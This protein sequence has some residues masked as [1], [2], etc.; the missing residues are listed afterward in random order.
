[1]QTYVLPIQFAA[2]S[3]VSLLPGTAAAYT[4]VADVPMQPLVL[5]VE[6][7]AHDNLVAYLTA[8]TLRVHSGE[9]SKQLVLPFPRVRV[10]SP[11]VVTVVFYFIQGRVWHEAADQVSTCLS[12]LTAALRNIVL[13]YVGTRDP[14]SLHL[15]VEGESRSLEEWRH[16]DVLYRTGSMFL[17]EPTTFRLVI[18]RYAYQMWILGPADLQLHFRRDF[19]W[20]TCERD[21]CA[22]T[23]ETGVHRLTF[24]ACAVEEHQP[25]PWDN[26]Y[27]RV[28]ATGLIE[29]VIEPVRLVFVWSCA[30]ELL[31][32][33]CYVGSSTGSGRGHVEICEQGGEWTSLE[34]RKPR[35]LESLIPWPKKRFVW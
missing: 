25:G 20:G 3:Q 1:M 35:S 32:N 33:K 8:D 16:W 26:I 10:F 18:S 13:D 34:D 27:L 21:F 17:M 14:R 22:E 30:D 28:T 23:E 2:R 6:I 11:H 7:M 24:A 15:R 5:R 12:P 19:S 29:G 4:L 31:F 9:R